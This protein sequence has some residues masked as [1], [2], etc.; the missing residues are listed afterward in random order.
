MVDNVVWA[1][2]GNFSSYLENVNI[3][4][5]IS[6]AAMVQYTSISN[7]ESFGTG[8][9]L[10]TLAIEWWIYM[11]YGYY[12]LVTF[13]K[14][15]VSI[16]NLLILFLFAAIPIINMVNAYSLTLSW[17]LGLVCFK[18]YSNNIFEIKNK[19]LLF[20]I[21][22][23]LLALIIKRIVK[24]DGGYDHVTSIL[25]ASSMLLTIYFFKDFNFGTYM[26][27]IIAFFA[28]YSFSLYL[29]H[30]TIFAA[31]M[32]VINHNTKSLHPFFSFIILWIICNLISYFFG[33]L[34]EQRL[35][36]YLRSYFITNKIIIK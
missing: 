34:F 8:R 12:I 35:T 3:K 25:I 5:F 28:N 1:I 14:N 16:L 9:P 13:K 36:K 21:L 19:P 10:W 22:M 29:I 24:T 27:K 4:T 15:N 17:V 2:C 18:L 11:A 23:L 33:F 32:A 31:G 6:N 30:Y 7:T 20:I 26:K